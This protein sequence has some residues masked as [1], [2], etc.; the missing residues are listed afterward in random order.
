MK[1]ES[2]GITL[3]FAGEPMPKQS[4][5]SSVL[6]SKT[7]GYVAH[8]YQPKSL[9]R[10][11]ETLIKEIKNQLPRGFKP[12]DCPLS[13]CAEFRFT[14]PKSLKKS[15]REVIEAGGD[16]F[17]PTKPDIVDNLMKLPC[18]AMEGLVYTND[19]RI[20]QLASVK[21]YSK[22]ASTTFVIKPINET[23]N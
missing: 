2:D 8:H 7:G 22:V 12:F 13:V 3:R 19:S 6:R 21:Y 5:R 9:V 18:D 16:V 17:K 10:K 14:P 11:K 23:F 15:D 4:V 20:S 1:T